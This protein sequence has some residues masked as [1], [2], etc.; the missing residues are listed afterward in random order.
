MAVFLQRIGFMRKSADES[1][2]GTSELKQ[3]AREAMQA[4]HL[5][6]TIPENHSFESHL[7]KLSTHL[8]TH[9]KSRAFPDENYILSDSLDHFTAGRISISAFKES[10]T[11]D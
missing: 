5:G 10:A 11:I 3:I 4:Y 8:Q 9:G 6:H 1:L 2:P 7:E